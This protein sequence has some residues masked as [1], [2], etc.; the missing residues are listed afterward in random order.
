MSEVRTLL[1]TNILIALQHR[2]SPWFDTT[3]EAV[4]RAREDGAVAINAIVFG[5]F[6]YGF[7][8]RRSLEQALPEGLLMLPIPPES[9]WFAGQAFAQHRASGGT[10]T[11]PVADFYIGGHAQADGLRLLTRDVA[12]FSTYFPDVE[13]VVPDDR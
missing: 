9:G 4:V 11:S 6:A 12:R 2:D 10:R 1:D 7:D 3:L 8:D 13:L 5:E